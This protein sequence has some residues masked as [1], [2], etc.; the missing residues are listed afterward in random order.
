M[1]RHKLKIHI[2]RYTYTYI[3][4][5]ILLDEIETK[6]RSDFDLISQIYKSTEA[7]ENQ[8]NIQ[9]EESHEKRLKLLTDF[10]DN[11]PKEMESIN[12]KMKS[13]M[14]IEQADLL[15]E[16]FEL[17]KLDCEKIMQQKK[18][19]IIEFLKELD[20]R[21]QT[22]VDSMRNFHRDIER[23]IKL[24]SEQ[25]IKLRDMMLNH[26]DQIE[27]KFLEDRKDIIDEQYLSHIHKLIDTLDEIGTKKEK[28][29]TTL[30]D[31]LEENAEK[32]AKNTENDFINK[33]ILMENHLNH[34]KE[35]VEEYLYEIKILYEKLEYRIK[36]RD[37]KIKEAEEKK[38]QFNSWNI[39]LRDKI[40]FCTEVYRKNDLQKRIINSQLKTELVKMTESYD[41]LKEKFQHFE[42]HDEL[43]FKEI[44]DMKSKSIKE[45]ALKVILADRTIKTQ[46][47]GMENIPNDNPE[48][49]TL[50][51]LQKDQ[52]FEE[53]ETDGK[54]KDTEQIKRK[55]IQNIM[56]KISIP[57]VKQVFGYIIQE[58]EFL[59]ERELIQSTENM[60]LDEKLPEYVE[61]ICRAL[62]IKSEQELNQLLELFYKHNL[63]N[64]HDDP[65]A[66]NQ[67]ID[68]SQ[69]ENNNN[70][71][72]KENDND[73]INKENDE[74]RI[75][76][77]E[78]LD[79]LKEFYNEKKK[80]AKEKSNTHIIYT[81]I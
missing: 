70:N 71:E 64:Q 7:V 3:L 75:D 78:V 42:K 51:E 48:G 35:K 41:S 18:N 50:D 46:Q 49:F 34:I 8:R 47:L 68:D 25:F 73:N 43:R 69:S 45:L 11:L 1:G 80:R 10:E 21:D 81:Y 36:I 15:Q 57:R 67:N 39:K 74:I 66:E 56:D 29:L 28:E 55:F 30:Q 16:K 76:P 9:N 32:A 63:N 62:N 22:Y 59:I 38:E 53:N 52:E 6:R 19:L 23:M 4:M 27:N 79:I 33:V 20:Y 14:E 26:L 2:V 13:L 54:D 44:Y 65:N 40:A 17:F 5:M 31:T 72:H 37:E 24:M 61:S 77:D 60:T 12:E 58:A